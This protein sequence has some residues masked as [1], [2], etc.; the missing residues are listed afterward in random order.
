MRVMLRPFH[1]EDAPAF[2]DLGVGALPSRGFFDQLQR[3]ARRRVDDQV[4]RSVVADLR[5]SLE[6][7]EIVRF[8]SFAFAE[9]Q[10]GLALRPAGYSSSKILA[11]SPWCH[12]AIRPKARRSSVRSGSG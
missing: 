12:Q 11:A 8:G 5:E 7:V 1:V 2:V 10:H 3:K 6:C 4:D 9:D